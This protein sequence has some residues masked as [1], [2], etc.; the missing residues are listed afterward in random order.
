MLLQGIAWV[1]R[2][3]FRI[4]RLRTDLLAPQA[5]SQFEQQTSNILFG[6]TRVASHDEELWLPESVEVKMEA[7]GQFVREEHEYSKYRLY[8]VNSKVVSSPQ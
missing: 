2:S 6:P 1:D 7:N 8:Q 4:V 3:D 5:A